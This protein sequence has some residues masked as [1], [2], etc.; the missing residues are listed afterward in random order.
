MPTNMLASD[1]FCSALTSGDKLTVRIAYDA[2]GNPEYI[3]KAAPGTTEDAAAWL[4][5]KISYN[6]SNNPVSIKHPNGQAD[7]AFAWSGRTGY[8][9]N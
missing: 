5:Q 6:A 1:F 9:W 4:I 8:T 7:F 2:T 3:G